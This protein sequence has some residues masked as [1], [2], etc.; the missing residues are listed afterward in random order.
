MLYGNNIRY[1]CAELQTHSAHA[2]LTSY[3]LLYGKEA[4]YFELR[5]SS[6]KR[7]ALIQHN[8]YAYIAGAVKDT[9]KSMAT[10]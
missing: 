8:K 5:Q 10:L 4:N 9:H 2:Q 6:C 3:I 1:P 7:N